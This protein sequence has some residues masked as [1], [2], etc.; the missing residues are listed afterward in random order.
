MQNGS[1]F[2]E[3]PSWLLRYNLREL[4]DGRVVWSQKT[5]RLAPASDSYR[6]VGIESIN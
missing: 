6:S 4:R 2:R 1:L 3:G 5:A